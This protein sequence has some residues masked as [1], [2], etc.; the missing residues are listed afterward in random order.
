ML[1]NA[2]QDQ[3]VIL[4]WDF[5]LPV[6]IFVVFCAL[7]VPIWAAIGAAAIAMLFLSGALPL[8]LVGESL[9]D[10]IDEPASA[11]NS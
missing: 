11:A 4:G 10:G 9:F 3:T 7:A 8:S 6:I 2:L 1:F 5:Y